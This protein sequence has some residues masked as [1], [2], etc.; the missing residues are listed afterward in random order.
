MSQLVLLSCLAALAPSPALDA[1]DFDP[2]G[3]RLER[4]V[5]APSD[6]AFEPT[7]LLAEPKTEPLA[8]P[9]SEPFAQPSSE[10]LGALAAQVGRPTQRSQYSWGP[11]YWLSVGA[12]WTDGRYDTPNDDD[13]EEKPAFS[14]DFGVYNWR[15]E[16]GIGLE[17]GLMRNTYELEGDPLGLGSADVDVWRGMLGLRVA[18]RGPEDSRFVPYARAGFMYRRDDGGPIK[19]DGI[20]WYAGLGCDIRITPQLAIGPSV[21]FNEAQSQNAQEWVFGVL[22]T[23]GF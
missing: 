10:P 13:Y 15:G 1:L 20:G 21:M 2:F 6:A 3:W 18:D 4:F 8:E 14:I 9:G 22:L 17:A 5:A 7:K 11:Q 16:M 12:H 19:D 23:F